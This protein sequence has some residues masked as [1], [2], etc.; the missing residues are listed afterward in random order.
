MRRTQTFVFIY[1]RV[2]KTSVSDGNLPQD[3]V[4]FHI[5][6]NR[7]GERGVIAAKILSYYVQEEGNAKFGTKVRWVV[8]N[9]GCDVLE[10][11]YL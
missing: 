11:L 7:M 9:Q 3:F 4:G 2:N 8:F 10:M 5:R 6:G 1:L